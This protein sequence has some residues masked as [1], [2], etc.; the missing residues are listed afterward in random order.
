MAKSR[1]T[2]ALT[3]D[4]KADYVLRRGDPPD[5]NAEFDH[6]DT[7]GV[8]ADAIRSGGYDVKC[9]GNVYNLLK[10]LKN[11]AARLP[12]E[13]GKAWRGYDIVFNIA[14]GKFGRNRESQVPIILEMMGIPFVGSD[15][16]TLGLTLDKV[17]AK[18]LLISE[19]IR[20]PKFMQLDEVAKL[21][22]VALDYPLIVK[23]RYEGSSKGLS[24]SSVV[25]SR[26]RLKKQAQWVIKNYKQPALIEEFIQGSEFTVAVLGNKTP[27]AL[28]VVQIKID[29]KTN[30]NNLFYTFSRIY[31]NTLD[32]VC[33]APISKKLEEKLKALAIKTYRAFE[34]WDFGRV[35][36][37]VDKK[38]NP[39][40]LEINPLPS[41]STEDVFGVIANMQKITYEE[42]I[43]KILREGLKRHGIL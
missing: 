23:P 12:A 3:Y 16:L 13:R 39:Y 29:G 35:D 8:I 31:S 30:L 28:P 21:N 6:P 27:R 5:A 19:G 42:M 34:C 4:V 33:P 25:T 24:D 41:L 10:S 2:I 17:M 40:V 11:C 26:N 43:L 38:G 32:Y 36:I 37:R 7:I 9:I 15:G 20:T 14:E 1:K 18:K 22:G